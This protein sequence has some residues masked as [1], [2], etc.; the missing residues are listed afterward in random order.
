MDA[1]TPDCCVTRVSEGDDVECAFVK[2]GGV[3]D[4]DAGVRWFWMKSGADRILCHPIV[5]ALSFGL[6]ERLQTLRAFLA[7]LPREQEESGRVAGEFFVRNA[8]LVGT[9]MFA[10]TECDLLL[11]IWW[12]DEKGCASRAAIVRLAK[13]LCKPP[14]PAPPKQPRWRA[15][16]QLQQGAI[17]DRCHV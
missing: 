1:A 6:S 5:G 13:G 9:H 16:L 10:R 14:P 2:Y 4:A 12:V 8:P 7:F 11:S 3:P 17:R 15:E